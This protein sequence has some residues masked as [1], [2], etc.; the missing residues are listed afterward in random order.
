MEKEHLLNQKYNNTVNADKVKIVTH[1]ENGN[2]YVDSRLLITRDLDIFI[3]NSKA[4]G[5]LDKVMPEDGSIKPLSDIISPR[6]P[7]GLEGTFIKNSGF[8]GKYTCRMQIISVQ[9]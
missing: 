8:H 1:E 3:R 9:S 6:K 5:I 4:I 2:L 7:F